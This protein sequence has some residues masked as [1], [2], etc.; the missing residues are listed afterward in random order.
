[1]Q[2]FLSFAA[3]KSKQPLMRTT[4]LALLVVLTSSAFAQKKIEIT[5]GTTAFLNG[6]QNAFSFIIYNGDLK[7]VSKA[8]EKQLKD[9]KGKVSTK[10]EFFADDCKVKEMGPNTFDVYGKV[11]V[12]L[13]EGI[14]VYA[15][16]DLGGAYLSSAAHPDK[17]IPA[18]NILYNFAVEQTRE[19]VKVE[20]KLAEKVL[21]E[22]E[23]EHAMLIKQ[24]AQL[25]ASILD[26][27]K[28]IEETKAAIV[29]L[30]QAQAA[31]KSEV[32]VQKTVV[33]GLD[34]K[35]KAVN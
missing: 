17:V 27:Q 12:A 23:A 9:L 15:A 7:E 6:S 13:G 2:L 35:M 4:L 31:K 3:H 25:E 18:K 10:N 32:E 16:F 21:S 30:Q 5:E 22:R 34:D 11:E 8:W 26:H 20:I 28:K 24:Q 14:R 1:M 33:K 29:T 19:V